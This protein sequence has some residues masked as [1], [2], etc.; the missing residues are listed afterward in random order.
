MRGYSEL[1]LTTRC[2]WI[3]RHDSGAQATRLA[4]QFTGRMGITFSQYV[5]IYRSFFCE[6]YRIVIYKASF[7]L[8]VLIFFFSFSTDQTA[9]DLLSYAWRTTSALGSR[10]NCKI[11]KRMQIISKLFLRSPERIV[12]LGSSQRR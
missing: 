1:D 4:A 9:M 3:H 5:Y 2:S 8:F 11:A 10:E 6:S 12:K 7:F